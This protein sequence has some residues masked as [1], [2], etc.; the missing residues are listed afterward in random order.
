MATPTTCPACGQKF[1]PAGGSAVGVVTCPNPTC[2]RTF[3]AGSQGT[4]PVV[5]ATATAEATAGGAA[6]PMAARN[7]HQPHGYRPELLDLVPT[8][9]WIS[10]PM[11]AV[12]GVSVLLY[13]MVLFAV[14]SARRNMPEP[15]PPPLAFVHLGPLPSHKDPVPPK[16][17]AKKA[18]AT[19][20][21]EAKAEDE[22]KK[23][24]EPKKVAPDKAET[25]SKDDTTKPGPVKPEPPKAAIARVTP[26]PPPPPPVDPTKPVNWGPLTGLAGDCQFLDDGPALTINIPG[27]LHVFSPALNSRNAPCLL[28]DVRGDF[29]AT[30]TVPGKILPGTQPLPPLPF[31]LQAAGLILWQDEGNYLKLE[32]TSMFTADHKRAHQVIL[33][34]CRGGQIA[35]FVNR[36]A[37]DADITL[38]FKRTGS[39]V[40]CQYSPDGKTWL[41]V[42]RQN[43]TFPAAVKVG[44]LASNVSTKPLSARLERFELSGPEGRPGKGN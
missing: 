17:D 42:K 38:K 12:G 2:A 21:V 9:F 28:T 22:A 34:L 6:G 3:D 7:G 11:I 29:T 23:T 13:G 32:R 8:S 26:A 39:E 20:K 24:P 30:V 44:V 5:V 19:P 25:P 37:K 10:P 27:T 15:E 41:D 43:V 35:G 14:V 33:E 16:P 18:K 1:A 36:D 4:G 40:R 31:T